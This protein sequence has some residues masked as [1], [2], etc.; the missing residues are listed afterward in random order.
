MMF[1]TA[2]KT[3]L[4]VPAQPKGGGHGPRSREFLCKSDLTGKHLDPTGLRQLPAREPK[5]LMLM[6]F[7][8]SAL[9]YACAMRF[10]T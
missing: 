3:C 1:I 4:F 8:V 2:I 5:N 6:T 10:D 9:G 7:V